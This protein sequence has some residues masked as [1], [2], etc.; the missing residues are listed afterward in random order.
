MRAQAK[1]TQSFGGIT[2]FTAAENK[3]VSLVVGVVV[4]L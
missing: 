1:H 4:T 3:S 2:M